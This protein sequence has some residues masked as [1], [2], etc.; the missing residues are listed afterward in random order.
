MEK[1]TKYKVTVEFP[2]S[3]DEKIKQETEI[4][5]KIMLNETIKQMKNG[6]YR[7]A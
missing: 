7:K 6:T 4:I 1:E 3:L 2:V 5:K